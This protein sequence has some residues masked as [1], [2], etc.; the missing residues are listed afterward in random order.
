MDSADFY[1]LT[2]AAIEQLLPRLP[3]RFLDIY[4]DYAYAGEYW[5][6]VRALVGALVNDRVAVS[7]QERD[8]LYQ[9]VNH[10]KDN[11]EIL[12]KLNGLTVQPSD[13]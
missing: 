4:E 1:D 2:D 8:Q 13:Q 6:L 12:A 5:Y 9:I 10:L 3:Q 11:K 7:A